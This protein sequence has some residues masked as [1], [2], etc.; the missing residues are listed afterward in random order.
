MRA[1]LVALLFV[2]ALV[3]CASQ[4]TSESAYNRGVSAYRAKDYAA[5][6]THWSEAVAGG[7]VSALN[8]LGYLLYYGLGGAPDQQQAVGLWRRAA[9]RGHSEAQWHLGAAFQEGKALPQSN[10]EAYAWYRC[11]IASTEAASENERHAEEE[12][13][14][15]ARKSLAAIVE[16]LTPE[17]FASGQALAKQYI[18]AYARGRS[19]A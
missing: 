4:P 6:R 18:G 16:R 13:A 15:D 1:Y 17:Q 19:G 8:N 12:I 11:A 3:A 14:N 5:A 7:D 2:L 9:E 10:V